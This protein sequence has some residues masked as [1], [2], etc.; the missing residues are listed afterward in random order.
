M[1]RR[2]L[3]VSLFAFL[4]RL[5]TE[6]IA[7]RLGL[8]LG[9]IILFAL[10]GVNATAQIRADATAPADQR[11]TILQAGNGVP[12]VN[13]QTPT[14]G[15][16]SRNTYSQFDVDRNGAILNNS[17]TDTPTQL[18]GWVQGNP[19]LGGGSAR[20]I[21]NEV[22]STNPSHLN[23]WIEVAGKPAQVITAN[24]AG[25]TCDGCGFI[26]T[27]QA[28]LATGTPVMNRGSLDGY[29]VQ[30][31]QLQIEGLGLDGRQ[32]DAVTILT[33]SA[34]I[35]AALWAKRLNVVTG[36]NDVTVDA[37]G[38]PVDIQPI[39]ISPFP[40]NFSI[41]T[42]GTQTKSNTAPVFA[43]DVAYLGG[44][45]AGHIFLVGSEH[46]LGVRNSGT[47]FAG[48]QLT[49][50]SNGILSVKDKGKITAA[51]LAIKT[52][53]AIDNAG[54][55]AAQRSATIDTNSTLTNTG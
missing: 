7:M 39:I 21:L 30:G 3:F 17:R 51:E 48:Q 22:N 25:I 31:G 42:S 45:Y 11:P 50:D 33:R 53:G 20:I 27:P 9:F 10:A 49:L 29:R 35:N 38:Q 40:Q 54:V 14:A 26:N 52:E 19:W 8:R 34:E 2:S 47:L 36:T 46:G 4:V 32:A 43:L 41:N 28:T 55:I 23:G 37:N 18:G 16:V 15:G 13:I 6:V 24:P 5:E 1:R 12:L 44:M